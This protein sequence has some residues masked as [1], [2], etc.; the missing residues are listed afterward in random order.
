MAS[1]RSSDV[2]PLF[3]AFN[4]SLRVCGIFSRPNL[5]SEPRITLRRWADGAGA[6]GLTLG[7]LVHV[8]PANVH[9]AFP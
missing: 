7:L 2:T 4:F 8:N 9:G 5:R 1:L 3:L 6:V